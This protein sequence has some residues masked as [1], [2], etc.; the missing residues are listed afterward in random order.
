MPPVTGRREESP[1]AA[2]VGTA[3]VVADFCAEEEMNA[4]GV[5]RMTENGMVVEAV[6]ATGQY[7]GY[8]NLW[9]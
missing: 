8:R 3:A 4:A 9:P 1:D 5:A 2:D 6:E 7:L